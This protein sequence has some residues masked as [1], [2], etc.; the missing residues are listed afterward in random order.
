V[1]C[2]LIDL[3]AASIF[4]VKEKGGLEILE[5]ITRWIPTKLLTITLGGERSRRCPSLYGSISISVEK[6]KKG[7]K[8]KAQRAGDGRG[9]RAHKR[10]R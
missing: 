6:R 2:S 4:R 5:I 7:E 3:V 1:R 8:R 9:A 10:R